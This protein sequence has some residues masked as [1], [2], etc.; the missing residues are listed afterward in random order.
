MKLVTRQ[1]RTHHAGKA[2]QSSGRFIRWEIVLLYGL[3]LFGY[4][5]LSFLIDF[6]GV[7]NR[8]LTIPFRSVI[9]LLS[10][11][12]ILYKIFV[13]HERFWLRSGSYWYFFLAFWALYIV[14]LILD[15]MIFPVPLKLPVEEYWLYAIG[16]CLIPTI[17]FLGHIDN[18]IQEKASHFVFALMLLTCVLA[19]LYRHNLMEFGGSGRLDLDYLNPIT[20]GHAGTSLVIMSLF[21]ILKKKLSLR[22]ILPYLT[23]PLGFFI[24]GLA[25]SRGPFLALIVV[26]CFMMWTSFLRISKKR[27]L[28]LL[29]ICLLGIPF[30]VEKITVSESS[31]SQRIGTIH[32]ILSGERE[33]A[34]SILW[35]DAW[36]QFL[37]NPLLG[38]SLDEKHSM[39]YPHNAI[40]ESFMA[41][42]LFGGIAFASLVVLAFMKARM[43][44]VN[45]LNKA[46][47]PLL[48]VQSLAGAMFSGALYTNLFMWYSMGAV[49]SVA[50]T[51]EHMR[52]RLAVKSCRENGVSLPMQSVRKFR[53]PYSRNV[54]VSLYDD[55]APGARD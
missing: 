10:L 36:E 34:R 29:I 31:M 9:L 41:T 27:I 23:L 32:E 21:F 33:E 35:R 49:F 50:S 43:I 30:L 55:G 54:D 12:I 4:Q 13:E 7:P 8:A 22:T 6:L 11:N 17:A 53:R 39:T 51:M 19:F 1:R 37:D 40:I 20:I 16:T 44:I 14:R 48:C 28:A 5:V 52:K 18:R 47:I 3:G 46:W 24:M 2:A 15:T 26:V 25:S 45:D 42:G 38:S